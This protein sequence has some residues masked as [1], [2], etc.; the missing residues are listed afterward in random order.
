[1][2]L[3]VLG[4]SGGVG[5]GLRTTSYLLDQHILLDGGTGVGDLTLDEMR[6]IRHLILTHAHLD[7]IA[8]FALML[9][10]IYDSF[11]HTIQVHAP[12]AV[13]DALK[14]SLF[15]W[16]VWPDFS[17]LPSATA[18]IIQFN[19][20]NEAEQFLIDDYQIEAI[21]LSHTVAS[22]AYL[23]DH[24]GSHICFFGD[25]G[26]TDKIWQRINQSGIDYP[27]I[28]E[29][30]YP[31][32]KKQLAADSGHY[33]AELLAN[34]LAKLDQKAKVYIQHLKPGSQHTIENEL[35]NYLSINRYQLVQP[36]Q[37]L[38]V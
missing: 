29:V 17:Q 16:Q 8:G 7:H 12:Q 5:K 10:S 25:T 28:V 13:I 4:C 32:D 9:S 30:S 38:S 35:K 6:Q 15:N 22:Y 19:I 23:I 27:I 24:N 37:N 14:N 36:K 20:V 11:Q 1:M 34:D 21:S 33:T 31:N 3:R 2:Q 26:P 18:P